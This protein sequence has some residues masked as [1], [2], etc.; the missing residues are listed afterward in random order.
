[1]SHKWEHI[2]KQN[3]NALSVESSRRI[4]GQM[5]KGKSCF[6]DYLQLSKIKF[7]CFQHLVN[8][9]IEMLCLDKIVWSFF[10]RLHNYVKMEKDETKTQLCKRAEH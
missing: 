1:M 10:A 4:G 5:G 3:W 9:L 6:I 7:I 8:F 2:K